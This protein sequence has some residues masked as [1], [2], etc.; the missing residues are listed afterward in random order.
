M[1]AIA[2]RFASEGA[3]V[4]LAARDEAASQ[5]IA[6]DIERRGGH[7]VAIGCDVTLSVSMSNASDGL[8]IAPASGTTGGNALKVMAPG[9]SATINASISYAGNVQGI[10]L[11]ANRGSSIGYWVVTLWRFIGISRARRCRRPAVCRRW[12]GWRQMSSP[13]RFANS[14]RDSVG[15]TMSTK[16]CPTKS[17][18]TPASR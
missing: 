9:S 5:N 17:T 13:C 3:R 10:F 1:T 8:A 18:G 16:G 14:S 4:A 2:R 6:S 11:L 7:A 15:F 12:L